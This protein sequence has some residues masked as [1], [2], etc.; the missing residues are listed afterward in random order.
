M[1]IKF[2]EVA[3]LTLSKQKEIIEKLSVILMHS[4][5]F[6]G[7]R[8]K[9]S[10]VNRAKHSKNW[11]INEHFH[12]WFEFNHISKGSVYTE[13]DGNEFL[14]TAGQSYLIPPGVP[15]S[16]RHNNTGDDGICIRF[17]IEETEKTEISKVLTIPQY[18]AFSSD[19]EKLILTG[20]LYS[21]QAEFAAWLLRICDNRMEINE[22]VATSQ[23]AIAPQVILYL[24]EYYNTRIKVEDISNALNISYRTLSRKFKTETGITILD[25]LTQIRLKKA[26]QLLISTKLSMYDIAIQSGYENEFYFSK[27]F[28]KHENMSPSS[29]RKNFSVHIKTV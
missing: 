23:N 2:Q 11:V 12:P 6:N 18:C 19:I 9:V 17:S 25:K 10:Y 28:K 16:H 26:K 24:K 21:T 27:A 1:A 15:H 3:R 20:N 5:E 7:A 13:I 14:V 29:Y 22:N 4:F 8:F